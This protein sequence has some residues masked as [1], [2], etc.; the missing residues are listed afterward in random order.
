MAMSGGWTG[1]QY[2]LVRGLVG[3]GIAAGFGA[4]LAGALASTPQ[5]GL[6]AAPATLV[7]M[8]VAAAGPLLE[9][10][11]LQAVA[12]AVGV[13]AALAL[14]V[15]FYDRTATFLL[16]AAWAV[17]PGSADLWSHPQSIALG[18]ILLAHLGL[19]PAPYLS[20][21]A[22]GRVDPGGDW[23]MPSETAGMLWVAMAATT[24]MVGPAHASWWYVAVAAGALLALVPARRPLVWAAWVL[25]VATQAL[26][27]GSVAPWWPGLLALELA[28]LDPAWIRPRPVDAGV[29]TV[30]Y[31]GSCGL[32]H[33]TVRLLLAEEPTGHAFRYAALDSHTAAARL[34][35]PGE[36][37]PDSIV[38]LT[39]DDRLLLRSDAVARVLERLGGLWRVL[40]LTLRLMPRALR[41]GAYDVV[42]A[43]RH[44][45]FARPEGACPLIPAPYRS[46]FLP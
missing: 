15:G 31:D 39:D 6:E 38:V 1:G 8:L 28:A 7:A 34:P 42:A 32:C 43:L 23:E 29:D 33:R 36:D 30:F 10:A 14:A 19:P 18:C 17:G 11:P 46:L 5:P 4:R 3:A 2:S 26:S 24:A 41:D 16:A 20:W 35:S 25:M 12:A 9:S 22:R 27:A 45:L 37:L 44:R 21:S 13:A 40:G